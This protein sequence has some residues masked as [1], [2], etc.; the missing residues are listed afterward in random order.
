MI[1]QQTFR[2]ESR[3]VIL[4]FSATSISLEKEFS[5]DLITWSQFDI[6]K[7]DRTVNE[8]SSIDQVYK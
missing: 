1:D 2:K 8:D 4:I 7:K 3:K 6:K 5:K